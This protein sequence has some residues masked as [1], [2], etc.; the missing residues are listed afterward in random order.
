MREKSFYDDTTLKNESKAPIGTIWTLLGKY[1]SDFSKPIMI[2]SIMLGVAAGMV[3]GFGK[4]LS[5][6]V[7][8]GLLT[9]GSD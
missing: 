1:V 2:A 3:I 9:K 5:F 6:C 4:F 7:N 8:T